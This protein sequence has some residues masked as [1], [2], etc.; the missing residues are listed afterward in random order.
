[1][2]T[3]SEIKVLPPLKRCADFSQP[4]CNP[5]RLANSE[6]AV[7]S[8]NSQVSSRNSKGYRSFGTS[9]S[10]EQLAAEIWPLLIPVTMMTYTSNTESWG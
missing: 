4:I 7:W 8:I 10:A 9:A 6:R 2:W 3:R 5:G 1:M